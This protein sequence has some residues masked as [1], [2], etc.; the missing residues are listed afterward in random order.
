MN[1]YRKLN[2][3]DSPLH[4]RKRFLEMKRM[5]KEDS[6]LKLDDVIHVLYSEHEWNL[7]CKRWRSISRESKKESEAFVARL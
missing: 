2:D 1:S 7:F 4:I 3:V 5:V 6:S